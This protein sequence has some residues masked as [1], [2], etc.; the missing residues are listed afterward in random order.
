MV[1]ETVDLLVICDIQNP[2][3]NGRGSEVIWDNDRLAPTIE[4]SCY[5]IRGCTHVLEHEAILIHEKWFFVWDS[6]S[7]VIF[8]QLV[9]LKFEPE[10][11]EIKLH[12][13]LSVRV[14]N[15]HHH[16]PVVFPSCGHRL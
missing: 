7:L 9:V 8:P 10:V 15:G 3:S 13:S 12:Q 1:Y 11:T 14:N 4:N 16:P 2:C 5:S 6:W